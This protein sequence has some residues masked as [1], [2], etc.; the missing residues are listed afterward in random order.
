MGVR[1]LLAGPAFGLLL[2]AAP[3]GDVNAL[4]A[5]GRLGGTVTARTAGDA[6]TAEGRSFAPFE[7]TVRNTSQWKGRFFGAIALDD[8][9]AG[10]CHWF[11][12]VEAGATA[13]VRKECRQRRAFRDW[14]LTA[15][16]HL[17]GAPKPPER[18]DL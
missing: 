10:T 11:V 5:N 7:L 15:K 2:L 1:A 9:K 14:D 6:W 8:G 3:P 12:E 16:A 17:V 13:N 18:E 4:D